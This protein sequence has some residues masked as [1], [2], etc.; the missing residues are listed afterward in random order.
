MHDNTNSISLELAKPYV[1]PTAATPLRF[2][3]TT[4]LGEEHPAG[5]KVVVDFSP[6]DI[7]NLTT[8][9]KSKLIKIAGVRYNPSTDRIKMSCENFEH[10]T[11]N[12]RYLSDLVDKLITE[13]K[14]GKD[15]FEDV[16][17]DFRHHKP[18]P[19][20][21]F[22]ESWK[23]TP[24]RKALLEAK[25]KAIADQEGNRLSSGKVVDGLKVVEEAIK[26]L[27]GREEIP[28]LVAVRAGQGERPKRRL[29]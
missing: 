15:T 9:Q 29:A 3:Y 4:Y 13:A 16:P 12:K 22:P 18:K 19:K 2:R 24:E 17:F 5:R 28:E 1:V 23:I 6:S 27:P 11:Q 10:A 14:D 21:E 20:Y 26:A 7:P 8:L 25:R